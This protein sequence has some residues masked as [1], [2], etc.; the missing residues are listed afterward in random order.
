MSV[1]TSGVVLGCGYEQ[2]NVLLYWSLKKIHI[3]KE[4]IWQNFKVSKFLNILNE[5]ASLAPNDV[6]WKDI[7]I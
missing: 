5:E 1:T 2:L 7:I 4:S 3:I 6:H